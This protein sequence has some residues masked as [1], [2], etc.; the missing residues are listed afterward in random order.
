M[1]SKE[2]YKQKIVVELRQVQAQL[3]EF[4]APKKILTA[5]ACIKYAKQIN[6]FKQ[7]VN[8]T[9]TQV[10][11]RGEANKGVWDLLRYCY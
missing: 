11:E 10:K 1:N 9:R 8:A 3:A 5:D 6:N 7:K 2:S 4:E